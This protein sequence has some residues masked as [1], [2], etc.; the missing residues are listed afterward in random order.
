L[1]EQRPQGTRPIRIIYEGLPDF[2]E[3]QRRFLKE[4]RLHC[5]VGVFEVGQSAQNRIAVRAVEPQSDDLLDE[6]ADTVFLV[7]K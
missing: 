6:R 3:L 1:A 2:V 4:F 7:H 5:F